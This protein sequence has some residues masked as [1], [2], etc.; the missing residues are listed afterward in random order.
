MLANPKLFLNLLL[1]ACRLLAGP[2]TK[3]K[4]KKKKT[5]K[6]RKKLAREN[7]GNFYDCV[8]KPVKNK[9]K[10]QIE[11]VILGATVQLRL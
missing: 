8:R 1:A 2:S 10:M 11:P 9:Y 6:K 7:P 5:K 4:K 3:K